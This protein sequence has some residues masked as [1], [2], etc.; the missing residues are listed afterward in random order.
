MPTPVIEGEAV[1][2]PRIAYLGRFSLI[3]KTARTNILAVDQKASPPTTTT[4]K[5]ATDNKT[6]ETPSTNE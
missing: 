2:P 5:D 3:F 4:T 6:D 1:M